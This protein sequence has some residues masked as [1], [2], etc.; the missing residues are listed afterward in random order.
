MAAAIIVALAGGLVHRFDAQA[1]PPPQAPLTATTFID[2]VKT[3]RPVVTSISALPPA[4]APQPPLPQDHPQIPEEELV[5]SPSVG[6]GVLIS[7]DGL[8]LT[9]NHVID[10]SEQLLVTLWN[11]E[12]LPAAVIGR[13]PKTDLALIRLKSDGGA[14][15]PAARL[16]DS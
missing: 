10:R 15:F 8:I 9:N 2:L 7:P 5:P 1:A 13:D 3:Q 16:G 6:T 4:D 14:R 11:G 12:Q